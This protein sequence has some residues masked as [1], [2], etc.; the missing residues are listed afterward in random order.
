M[1]PEDP[2]LAPLAALERAALRAIIGEAPGHAATLESQAACV[3]VVR[4]ENSGAGCFTHLHVPDGVPLL[5]GIST[6]GDETHAHVPGLEHGL[7]FVLF[8]KDG[9]LGL[10][11]TYTVE[12]ESTVALDFE[13]LAFEIVR[14]PV[15]RID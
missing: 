4:R 15:M 11:E 7:G 9:K 12:P 3:R 1:P 10:L 14:M 13:T 5:S 6:L 2:D 8:V